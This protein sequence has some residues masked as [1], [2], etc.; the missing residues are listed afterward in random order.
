MR[1]TVCLS[2]INDKLFKDHEKEIDAFLP[3]GHDRMLYSQYFEGMASPSL[4]N[5]RSQSAKVIFYLELVWAK[6]CMQLLSCPYFTM[7][8]NLSKAVGNRGANLT[9]P[10]PNQLV[11]VS[12]FN[13][14]T[15]NEL[16][17]SMLAKMHDMLDEVERAWH[18]TYHL[19]EVGLGIFDRHSVLTKDNNDKFDENNNSQLMAGLSYANELAEGKIID[20]ILNPMFQN[21]AKMLAAGLCTASQYYA[22]MTKLEER[23]IRYKSKY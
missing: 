15:A 4:Y 11:K 5:E 6:S 23:V 14:N 2:G 18:A 8:K 1:K 3:C 19:L 16:I 17:P 12:S 21:E 10:R 7:G 13:F 22:A 9:T 20:K